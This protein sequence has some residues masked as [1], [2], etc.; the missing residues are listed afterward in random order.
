MK[1]VSNYFML[2]FIMSGLISKTVMKIYMLPPKQE[3]KEEKEKQ[4]GEKMKIELEVTIFKALRWEFGHFC[5]QVLPISDVVFY[6]K[7]FESI[8]PFGI[9]T[10]M[11]YYNRNS[12]QVT[13]I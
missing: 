9:T 4:R 6:D 12:P 5:L 7:I 11:C 10:I 13:C 2:E 3:G 8:M 1:G